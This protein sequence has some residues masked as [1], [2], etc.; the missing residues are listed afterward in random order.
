[1]I[2]RNSAYG[3][4]LV[5]TLVVLSTLFSSCES[6]EPSFLKVYVR[7]ENDQLLPKAKVIIIGDTK[8]NPPT[9]DFVD[10]VFTDNAG[11][12]AFDLEEFFDL[13]GKKVTSGY[14]DILVKYSTSQSTGR[15]RV[16]KH[17]TSVE[18]VKF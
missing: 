1:M 15:I 18:T 3:L 4:F 9:I 8:S 16:K 5:S 10:T 6:K 17:V 11:V 12:A 7:N 2:K 13:S 14:F